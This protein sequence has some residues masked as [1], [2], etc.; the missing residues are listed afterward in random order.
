MHSDWSKTHVYEYK[1]ENA[2]KCR[3]FLPFTCVFYVSLVFSNSH[4]VLSQCNTRLGLYLLIETVQTAII[5]YNCAK[6]SREADCRK[7][8]LNASCSALVSLN[9]TQFCLN[10]VQVTV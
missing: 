3:K 2:K 8:S 7:L 5:Q 9:I 10:R 1:T 4:C 6:Q